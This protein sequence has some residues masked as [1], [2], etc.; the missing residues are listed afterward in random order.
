MVPS[1]K[2]VV[3]FLNVLSLSVL[4]SLML[5]D[6]NVAY[7]L[8]FDASHPLDVKKESTCLYNFLRASEFEA[9][10]RLRSAVSFSL[11]TEVM[12]VDFRIFLARVSVKYSQFVHFLNLENS[13]YGSN[14]F[15]ISC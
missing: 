7:L 2:S 9:V 6:V 4:S 12:L 8:F 14:L 11:D 10:K 3:V 1:D 15:E 5:F 13:L